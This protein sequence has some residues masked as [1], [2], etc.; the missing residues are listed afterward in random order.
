[1]NQRRFRIVWVGVIVLASVVVGWRV[2]TWL[3]GIAPWMALVLLLVMAIFLI[4]LGLVQRGK[5]GGLAGAFG[6]LGGQ[7]AFGTK[8]G[9]TFTKVTIAVAAAWILLCLIS[10][11]ALTPVKSRWNL[12]GTAPLSGEAEKGPGQPAGETGGTGNTASPAGTGT[13]ATGGTG[14]GTSGESS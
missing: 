1:V 14:G 8:A 6:G 9:D 11:Q 12:G 13:G 3:F 5:G 7:S 4:A 10:V 2:L